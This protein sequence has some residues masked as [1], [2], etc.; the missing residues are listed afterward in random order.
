MAQITSRE[1]LK[2]WL[3]GKPTDWAQVIAARAALRVLPYA[4]ASDV[5]QNWVQDFASSLFRALLISWAARNFPAHDM[6]RAAYAAANAAYAADAAD[7]AAYAAA[8]AAADAANAAASAAA[9]AAADAANA[10][11]DAADAADAAARAAAYAAARAAAYAA[12]AAAYAAAWENI[13]HDCKWLAEEGDPSTASRRLTRVK[14]WPAG[15]PE[16]WSAAWDFATA[17][18]RDLDQGYDVWIDW[19]NRRITGE[20]A[21]FPIEGDTNRVEDKKILA[22]LADATNEDFWDKGAEYVNATLKE[23][24]EEARARVAPP[25]QDVDLPEPRPQN[26]DA[27]VWQSDAENRIGVDAQFGADALDISDEARDRHSEARDEAQRVRALCGKS[28]AAYEIGELFDRYIESLGETI[29]A[30]RPGQLV[31]RGERLR[32][33][34]ASRIADG[35][36]S[37]YGPLPDQ[38]RDGLRGWQS[39]HNAFVG[40]D[41]KLARIDSALY[42]PDARRIIVPP[43]EIR[44]IA[45]SADEAAILQPG[46]RNALE[47]TAAIGPVPPD[48]DDRRSRLSSETAK[49]FGRKVLSVLWFGFKSGTAGYALGHWV[50]ANADWFRTWFADDP[51]TLAVV[52]RILDLLSK[53]PLA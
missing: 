1:E 49:N 12:D 52:E 42:G 26:P 36:A 21:A 6:G 22:A 20:R 47:E 50:L 29:E 30:A 34:L 5:R 2:A 19:Y 17:R 14:L 13:N 18:L 23:W 35:A 41:P 44:A 10:A 51:A 32:Q 25:P 27:L 38:V 37:N 31:Q 7:A 9:R 39:A 4:F 3:E 16:G 24:I 28:D 43:D 53:L 8:R 15:E 45:K 48:A 11:A 40:L 33:A 46:G